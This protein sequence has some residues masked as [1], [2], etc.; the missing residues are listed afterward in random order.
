MDKLP[1]PEFQNDKM[2]PRLKLGVENDL[3]AM[4]K[5]YLF[6]FAT[7]AGISIGK[8][9]RDITFYDR[10]FAKFLAIGA[11][12]GFAAHSIASYLAYDPYHLAALR[13]NQNE[14]EFIRKYGELLREYRNK[15]VKVPEHLLY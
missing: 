15:N 4:K 3:P 13:N 10:N 6:F 8:Y 2:F 9:Y 7:I 14:E 1:E 5:K 11:V 12:F